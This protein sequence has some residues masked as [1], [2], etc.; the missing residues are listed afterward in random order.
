MQHKL[1]RMVAVRV[2]NWDEFY[3]LAAWFLNDR[4]QW[5]FRGQKKA[6]WELTTT[7]E[8]ESKKQASTKKA[9]RQFA[10]LDEYLRARPRSNES[11]QIETFKALTQWDHYMGENKLPYL[12]A[13]QHY[14][15][16]TRLLDF[17]HSLFIAA[18]FAFEDKRSRGDRAVWAI[19]LDPVWDYARIILGIPSDVDDYEVERHVQSIGDE[20]I[21]HTKARSTAVRYGVLP[22]VNVG[23]NPRLK[24]QNGLFLMPFTIDGFLFNL[25][26]AFPKGFGWICDREKEVPGKRYMLF[27]DYM[28]LKRK[29]EVVVMKII[30]SKQMKKKAEDVFRQMNLTT[31]RL[32]PDKSFADVKDSVKYRFWN[33]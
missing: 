32:F 22:L 15:F 28:N 8:R 1:Y 26:R 3:R 4:G 14:G 20:L 24:A 9:K 30:C 21:G 23:D 6:E 19:R 17:T 13:M 27:D 12:A 2:E 16:P 33:K 29:Q 7:L 11:E 5:V 25:E 31:E 18:Y 10:T